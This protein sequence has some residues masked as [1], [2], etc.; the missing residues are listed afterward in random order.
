MPLAVFLILSGCSHE[1]R[2]LSP[3]EL[4]EEIARTVPEEGFQPVMKDAEQEPVAKETKINIARDYVNRSPY[5]LFAP[6]TEKK[7]PAVEIPAVKEPVEKKM[8]LAEP[9]VASPP[10]QQA[11][12]SVKKKEK[13]VVSKEPVGESPVGGKKVLDGKTGIV[14]PST[15]Q[16]ISFDHWNG[17]CLVYSI[18]W[19]SIRFGKGILACKEVHNRHGNIYRII[20]LSVP[21]RSIAGIKMGLYRMDAFIDKKSL[22]PHYYYQYSKNKNKEDI[23][24]IRFDWNKKLY[25]TKYRK[26]DC[27][28]LYSTK[29]KTVKIKTDTVY[30]GISIFY[31]VRTLDLE[32]NSSFIIPIAFKEIWNLTIKKAGKRVENIPGMGEKEV[33]VLKPHA[34]SNGGFLTKGAMYLWLTADKKRLP[35]YMEGKVPLG[36]AQMSLISVMQLS[37]DTIFDSNTITDILSRFNK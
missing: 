2:V 3:E 24:E 33:Y 26:F 37:P 5:D 11:E 36:K 8:P 20:G 7:E 32:R 13:A 15:E 25:K 1:R 16:L 28:K 30:D 31:V 23:L 14:S 10:E 4:K 18:M 21:D 29:E 22:L 34:K 12:T 27:R 19:N 9:P 6:K 35:V 17:E